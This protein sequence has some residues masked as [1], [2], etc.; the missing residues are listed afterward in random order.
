MNLIIILRIIVENSL[1]KNTEIKKLIN[2]TVYDKICNSERIF[3]HWDSLIKIEIVLIALWI[4]KFRKSDYN[5]IFYWR[6]CQKNVSHVT[7]EK[8]NVEFILLEN[9]KLWKIRYIK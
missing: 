8:K 4:F 3:S 2:E 5:D 6:N 7:K 1:S 9:Q